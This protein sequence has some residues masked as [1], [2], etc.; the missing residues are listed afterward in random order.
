MASQE[1]AALVAKLR[2]RPALAGT[3]PREWRDQFDS[4]Y[5][6]FPHADGV[7][8]TLVALHDDLDGEWFRGGARHE[9]AILYVHGGGYMLGSTRSHGPLICNLVAASGIGALGINYRLAPEHP[10]PAALEDLIR[11]YRYLLISGYHPKHIAIAGD[12]AGGG[13]AAALLLAIRDRGMPLPACSVLMS[14]WMDLTCSAQ[15]LQRNLDSDPLVV[16]DVLE[17]MASAY[18]P[19]EALRDDP[20]VSPLFASLTGLPPLL[21][22]VS[23]AE[24]LEDDSV[25]FAEKAEKAGVSVTLESTDEVVHVWHQ[26][27]HL[28]PEGRRA[29]DR[30]A[31][32]LRCLVGRS[33]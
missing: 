33:G 19:D 23:T 1:N 10:F 5:G 25:R 29:I 21:I 7:V 8:R 15:S 20:L 26:Y 32:F 27:A 6:D 24:V 30:A 11:G 28:I 2:N 16:R 14:P 4:S 17:A 9:A 22:Q 18:V 31:D 13:L 12:S 3:T